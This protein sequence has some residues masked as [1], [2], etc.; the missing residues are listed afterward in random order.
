[1]E[2]ESNIIHIWE[3]PE[4]TDNI[5]KANNFTIIHDGV[6]LKK[7]TLQKLYEYFNLEFGMVLLTFY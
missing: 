1:M 2:N 6:N 3:L 5:D 7:V 4:K